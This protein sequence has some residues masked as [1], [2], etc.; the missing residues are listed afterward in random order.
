L[1]LDENDPPV[2]TR[3][4]IAARVGVSAQTVLNIANQWVAAGG[5]IDKVICYKKRAT[6]PVEPKL[7][8]Q[9]EARLVAMAC[10]TPPE[11]F[12]RWSLRLL[13]KK[14]K[15]DPTLPDVDHSTIGRALKKTGFVLI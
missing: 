13:E 1:A 12:C 5:V 6:P 4:Q 8:G 10:S 11:G 3:L 7:D 14:V 15:L 2:G 9:V